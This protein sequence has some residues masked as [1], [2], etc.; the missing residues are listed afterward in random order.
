MVP[1]DTLDYAVG[2]DFTL[3]TSTR[4]NFQ[5]F[6]RFFGDYDP[7]LVH[8]EHEDGITLL[9]STKLGADWEPEVLLINSLNRRD[10]LV[11]TRLG[12]TPA[13]NWRLV[14]GVDVFSGEATGFF[15]R[16]DGND[17]AYIEARRDF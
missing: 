5:L 8:E 10:R 15:G 7:D 1:Q 11:R 3:G 4:L 14:F 9:L 12:W 16:F 6:Q 17:R 13:R 2:L